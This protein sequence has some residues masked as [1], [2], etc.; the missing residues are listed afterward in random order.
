[1]CGGEADEHDTK[2]GHNYKVDK[3]DPA[4]KKKKTRKAG[5]GAEMQSDNPGFDAETN[6]VSEAMR[7]SEF[8]PEPEL[9][10]GFP[11]DKVEYGTKPCLEDVDDEYTAEDKARRLKKKQTN[12]VEEAYE[13]DADFADYEQVSA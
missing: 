2:V 11:E 13:G 12:G 10:Q 6:G 7:N 4:K 1:M 9:E 5:K 3:S 8:A